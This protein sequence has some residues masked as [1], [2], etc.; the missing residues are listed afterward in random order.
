MRGRDFRNRPIWDKGNMT[1]RAKIR[2]LRFFYKPDSKKAYKKTL[3]KDY[4]RAMLFPFF[5]NGEFTLISGGNVKI[6]RKHFGMLATTCRMLDMGAWVKWHEDEIEVKYKGLHFFAPSDCKLLP[7]TLK[8]LIDGDQWRLNQSQLNGG[9]VLDIGAHIGIFSIMAAKKGA[10]VH[11][12]EPFEVF[13]SY[14]KRNCEQNGV[15][16]RV[17]V[18]GVGL[19]SKNFEESKKDQLVLAAGSAHGAVDTIS[20][21][22]I[23][24]VDAYQF[25]KDLNLSSVELLKSNCEGGEYEFFSDDRFLKQVSPKRISMEF[26]KGAQDLISLFQRLGYSVNCPENSEQID[27]PIKGLLFAEMR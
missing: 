21:S 10:L 15:A 19:S 14:I 27:P 18:H 20:S 13:Q 9:V 1:L 8:F 23:K 25:T 11:A 2:K 3:G 6:P 16:G 7:L 4:I 17:I 12:F 26:H 5:G 24:M 22:T